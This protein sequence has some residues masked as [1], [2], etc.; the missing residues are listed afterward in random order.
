LWTAAKETR[1]APLWQ[2]VIEVEL[3]KAESAIVLQALA[4]R[5]RTQLRLL[6]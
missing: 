3:C 6:R 1:R 4:E 5:G 2:E